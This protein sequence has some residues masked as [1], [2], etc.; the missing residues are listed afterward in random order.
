MDAA[1]QAYNDKHLAAL[2]AEAEKR[3][4]VAGIADLTDKVFALFDGAPDEL[5]R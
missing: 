4:A 2:H 3:C 5:L 1:S